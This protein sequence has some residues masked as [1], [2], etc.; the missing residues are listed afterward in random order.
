MY[1]LTLK[2][3]A[4]SYIS[5]DFFFFDHYRFVQASNNVL[6]G[7]FSFIQPVNGNGNM[8]MRDVRTH[9]HLGLPAVHIFV[10]TTIIFIVSLNTSHV[11]IECVSF[12][13]SCQTICHNGKVVN[14][15]NYLRTSFWFHLFFP[16]TLSRYFGKHSIS[17][18][19]LLVLW[20]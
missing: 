16:L 13:F 14:T 1:F 11:Y 10:T 17:G 3:V 4:L 9:K 8:I 7:R 5:F 2:N 12:R 20:E 19:I 15:T 18:Y 6:Q